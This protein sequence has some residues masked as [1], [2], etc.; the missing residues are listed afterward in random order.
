MP[1]AADESTC[2]RCGY[3]VRGIDGLT[4]P[5]CG[6]DLR[7]VGILPANYRRPLGPAMKMLLWS[8]ALPIPALL[9][10]ILMIQTVLPFCLTQK[11]SRVIFCQAPALNT[12]V[13]LSAEKRLWQPVLMS[14][15]PT[16]PDVVHLSDTN[17]GLDLEV[18]L[19][20]GAYSYLRKDGS[21]INQ[22]AGFN[23][24]VL[25]GWFALAGVSTGDPQARQLCDQV[26]AAIHEVWQGNSGHFTYF[27]DARG[28]NIGVA[29][30]SFTFTVRDEP[31]KV[32]V[33]LLVVAWIGVWFYGLRRIRRRGGFFF[34]APRISA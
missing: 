7:E 31:S 27:N 17:H 4:C 16:A 25:A 5:E 20:T 22:P 8:V 30:P 6:S 26:Y 11:V 14:P 15:P 12:I 28:V 13:Q 19:S 32:V 23:G 34:A 24:A 29:H 33:A 3:C 9:L 18:N 1:T 10:S 21:I 2:G